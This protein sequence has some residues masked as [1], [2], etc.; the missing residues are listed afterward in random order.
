MY[1]LISHNLAIIIII[2]IIIV[3]QNEKHNCFPNNLNENGYCCFKIKFI[4]N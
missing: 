3:I 4:K 2:I 1:T